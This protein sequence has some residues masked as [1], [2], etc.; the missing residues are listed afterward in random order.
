M[1]QQ[2]RNEVKSRDQ[3]EEETLPDP[4]RTYGREKPEYESGMG[5]LDNNDDA[6]PEDRDDSTKQAVKNRHAPSQINADD[7]E[8]E[9]DAADAG[10]G[11]PDTEDG[12]PNQAKTPRYI[13]RSRIRKGQSRP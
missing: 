1:D 3:E 8:D 6:V 13:D 12:T 4:A 7:E 2:K 9:R 10:R 11:A 5:R